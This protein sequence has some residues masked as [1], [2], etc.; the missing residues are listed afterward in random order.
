MGWTFAIPIQ[1][2]V[3][4][5]HPIL[6][7]SI[8][9]QNIPR[10]EIIFCTEG[11]FQFQDQADIKEIAFP[12][13]PRIWIT[14]KKNEI[15]KAAQYE[16]ICYLHDYF[17]LTPGWYEG[18]EQFGYDW[19]VCCNQ[20]LVMDTEGRVFDW[21]LG[22]NGAGEHLSY[23]VLD[24]T[25]EQYVSGGYWCAKKQFMLDNPLNENL[26]WGDNEDGEWS[27]RVR[28]FWKLK[29]NPYSIVRTMKQPGT[30]NVGQPGYARVSSLSTPAVSL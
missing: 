7:E 21:I 14:K 10:Y 11:P 18:F 8:R 28:H 24:R 13:D 29:F 15:T 3:S 6:I 16:N 9:S 5:F 27:C 2:V 26:M 17:K 23:D 19:D 12:P 4:P 30:A 22:G 20:A 1:G 25:Q